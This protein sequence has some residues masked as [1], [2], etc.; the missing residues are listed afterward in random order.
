MLTDD[1]KR[2]IQAEEIYRLEVRNSS[3][4]GQAESKLWS[5]LNSN[6]GM[7]LISSFFLSGISF[8][9]TAYTSSQDATTQ[10]QAAVFKLTHELNHR[11]CFL[12]L[13]AFQP[14]RGMLQAAYAAASGS[15]PD[16]ATAFE[17]L[18][19][20][21]RGMSMDE[22]FFNL[23]QVAGDELAGDLENL[24]HISEDVEYRLGEIKLKH[25]SSWANEALS[26]SKSIRASGNQLDSLFTQIKKNKLYDM[27][28]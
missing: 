12:Q 28:H 24:S 15:E 19:E 10:Q 25:D 17:P 4:L 6:F 20:E 27:M 22:L 11:I 18:F 8:I 2:R 16:T 9:Y 1:E 14:G 3:E 26:L 7:L 21:Y 13:P 5:F 23:S